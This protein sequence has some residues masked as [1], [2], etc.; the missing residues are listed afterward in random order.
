MYWPGQGISL[1]EMPLHKLLAIYTDVPV[2]VH[3]K[4]KYLPVSQTKI[5]SSKRS[6]YVVASWLGEDLPILSPGM[7][8]IAPCPSPPFPGLAEFFPFPVALVM[9]GS[10]SAL[11]I[12]NP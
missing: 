10:T 11:F 9:L 1:P 8:R 5:K 7:P 3:T 2:P 4:T 6:I 12:E